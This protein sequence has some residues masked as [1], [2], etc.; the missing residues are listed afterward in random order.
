MM[1]SKGER[2]W[3]MLPGGM[4]VST[5]CSPVIALVSHMSQ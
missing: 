3:G 4:V 5:V 2:Q 1:I